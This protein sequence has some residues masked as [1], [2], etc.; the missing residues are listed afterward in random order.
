MQGVWSETQSPC[1]L[2]V[3]ELTVLRSDEQVAVPQLLFE[4]GYT[5]VSDEPSQAPPQVVPAPAHP[6]R[7]PAG[8]PELLRTQVPVVSHTWH[9]PVQPVLQQIP[10]TQYPV[11]HS[12]VDVQL[13]P[14]G[15]L[16][17]HAPVALQC[18]PAGQELAVQLAAH[19]PLPSLAHR[20]LAHGVAA[21]TGQLPVLSQVDA[22]V[23]LPLAQLAW[24]HTVEMPGYTQALV[25][26]SH[27]P[28][29]VPE[30]PQALRV[31]RGSPLRTLQD[32]VVPTSVHDSH[33]PSHTVLQ[34][35]PS[36]QL[37]DVHCALVEQF[38][39]FSSVGMQAPVVSQ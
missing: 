13:A 25:L 1:P 26:P 15:L 30:P 34:Q 24:L 23:A 10:S 18:W 28:L 38:L 27:W 6:A 36:T 12:A 17:T 14:G 2:H 4:P 3:V 11:V 9:C 31:P 19:F 7:E 16:G 21:G 39:P 37:P 35:T 22:G 5:Q 20:L 32:P 8:L 29:Q 33:C